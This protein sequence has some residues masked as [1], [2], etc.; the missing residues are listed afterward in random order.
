MRIVT[1]R[2][3]TA[4]SR[5]PKRYSFSGTDQL[6]VSVEQHVIQ[7]VVKHIYL[8]HARQ[9]HLIPWRHI[10]S[11]THQVLSDLTDSLDPIQVYKETKN[12]LARLSGW[13]NRYYLEEY[14]D[15]GIVN[16]PIKVGLGARL[17]YTDSIDIVTMG[18]KL[19]LYDFDEV[20]NKE[21]LRHYTG[22]KIYNNLGVLSRIWAFWKAA[23]TMPEEYVRLVIGCQTITPVKIT[24]TELLLEKAEKIVRQITRGIQD[25]VFYPAFSEQ[26][27]QCPFKK[28][29]SV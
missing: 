28:H 2:D 20:H 25:D 22:I 27:L 4:Y 26:C 9:G 12:L 18:K 6:K 29:C 15:E 17:T 21:A 8:Y 7:T 14:C 10:P 24:I 16:L 11:R 23:E 3:I 13:Y 19:R 1:A 5:C